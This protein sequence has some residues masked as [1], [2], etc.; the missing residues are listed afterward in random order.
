MIFS[1]MAFI[2]MKH[3]RKSLNRM[4]FIRTTFSRISFFQNELLNKLSSNDIFQNSSVHNN[5]YIV[6]VIISKIVYQPENVI[7][8]VVI[9]QA[10]VAP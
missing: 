9:L 10:V 3:S 8:I 5:V 2:P 4:A 7:L 1:T 6:A